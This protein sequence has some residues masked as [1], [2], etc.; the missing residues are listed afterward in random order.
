MGSVVTWP[1]TV[2]KDGK[3]SSSLS[4]VSCQRCFTVAV[5]FCL[6]PSFG[7]RRKG[8]P[9]VL[10]QGLALARQVLYHLS[11]APSPFCF[12]YFWDKFSHFMLWTR[13][14]PFM[15][16][17]QLGW[18]KDSTAPSFLLF[19]MVFLRTFCQGWHGT[20]ILLI[21]ASRVARVTGVTHRTW[22]M[23]HFNLTTILHTIPT[24]CVK[25]QMQEHRADCPSFPV[26]CLERLEVWLVFDFK[27]TV[28]FHC[29]D[30]SCLSW[31]ICYRVN[32]RGIKSCHPNSCKSAAGQTVYVSI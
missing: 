8:S 28:F 3:N 7:G 9:R 27:L 32:L 14:L 10:I 18:Q 24:S 4:F 26:A 29:L 5:Y 15:L 6:S 20:M 23:P 1:M 11:H 31:L 25:K 2:D 21:S 30:L 22:P 19:V 13:T 17:I 16:P 12:G